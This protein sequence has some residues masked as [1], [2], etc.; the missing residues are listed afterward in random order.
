M[1]RK[2]KLKHY[3]MNHWLPVSTFQEEGRPGM[4]S[5]LD[6]AWMLIPFPRSE[7]AV[8]MV[9]IVL[10]LSPGLRKSYETAD[11]ATKLRLC[12]SIQRLAH[13]SLKDF[14]HSVMKTLLK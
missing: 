8:N 13:Q 1:P 14:A 12:S 4:L 9:G 3:P 7:S 10:Y 2:E 11:K 5:D 6:G